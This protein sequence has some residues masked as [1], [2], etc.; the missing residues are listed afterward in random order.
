MTK[1]AEHEARVE[2][3][4]RAAYLKKVRTLVGYVGPR[5]SEAM[6]AAAILEGKT[7]ES[8]SAE[9]AALE[10]VGKAVFP[11][12][13]DAVKAANEWVRNR[14]ANM[15]ATLEAA[16]WDLNVV[17]PS[18]RFD[19]ADYRAKS[20]MRSE[21][22]RVTRSA[23]AV[24]GAYEKTNVVVLDP[25]GVERYVADAERDA[26]DTYDAFACKLVAKIGACDFADL[27]GS[28][29][30]SSS[31][32]TVRKGAVVERWKTQQITNVSIYNKYFPQWPTRLLK[33]GA[34]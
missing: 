5:V 30:W 11:V 3:N 25:E 24:R 32:L 31:I 4:K 18:P 20:A 9:L 1:K 13:L 6:I 7:A 19:D 12:K 2:A 23:E 34:K 22:H 14:V 27:D 17:A 33:V 15:T 8:Y 26:A 10:P 21:Y 28:H 16:N 29:V